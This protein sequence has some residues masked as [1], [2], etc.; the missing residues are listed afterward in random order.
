MWRDFGRTLQ[1]RCNAATCVLPAGVHDVGGNTVVCAGGYLP[2]VHM[3]DQHF[4]H[5]SQLLHQCDEINHQ[6]PWCLRLSGGHF[7]RTVEIF[8]PSKRQSWPLPPMPAGAYGARAAVVNQSPRQNIGGPN[9]AD[10][11]T[12]RT[13]TDE[14]LSSCRSDGR[15]SMLRQHKTER[16][17]SSLLLVMGGQ[18]DAAVGATKKT[19][20]L[21]LTGLDSA[22]CSESEGSLKARIP[23]WVAGP[24]MLVARRFFSAVVI[25]DGR[26]LICGGQS[27]AGLPLRSVELYDPNVG[28][29]FS[30]PPMAAARCIRPS[31]GML[32]LL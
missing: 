27:E 21:D 23:N 15:Q 5:L 32:C 22:G 12:T 30:M 9:N 11:S 6:V 17:P 10:F 18:S 20:C 31:A 7:S 13:S 14:L 2:G 8:V 1:P 19:W 25:P 28:C 3:L 4:S 29:W 16:Q 24:K 26:V